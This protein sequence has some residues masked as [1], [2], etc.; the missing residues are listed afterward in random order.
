M[1]GNTFWG[2]GHRGRTR[3]AQPVVGDGA[4]A[5]EGMVTG[6]SSR[7]MGAIVT[8]R[9]PLRVSFFGG[10][11]DVPDYYRR[12]YGAVVSTTIDKYVYVTIK[13]HGALFDEV[14]RLNYSKTEQATSVEE[15][16]N[17]SA[18]ES[19]RLCEVR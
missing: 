7:A 14:F 11:T 19:I 2:Q 1:S 10:G 17:E 3:P 18:R 9:T 5:L 4:G 15:I 13:L 8:T 16:E 6:S 12:G